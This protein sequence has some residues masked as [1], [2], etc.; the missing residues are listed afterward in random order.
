MATKITRDTIESYLNCKYKGHLKLAG[1]EGTKSDYELLLA[2]SREEVR[3]Q[4][5]AQIL[6]RHPEEVVERDIPLT[7]AALK[8]GAAFVLNA[9]LDDEHVSLA[10]DGLKRVPGPSKLGDFHYV[11]M[12]FYEARQIRKPQRALVDLYGL[13]LSRLQGRAPGYG[14]I[15]HGK[16]CKA[17]RV[18][19]NPDPRKAE[20]LLDELRQAKTAEALPRLILNDHCAVCEFRPRCQQ[21]AVQ[22]DN[23][24]LLRGMKEK[25]VKAYARKGIL[26]VTQ[27]AHTFRPRRK[28]KRAPPRPYRH[29]HALQ[30]LAAR[31]KKVYVF[32]TPQL[33]SSPVRIYLDIE[34]NPE[35]GFDYLVGLIVIEGDNQERHSFWADTRDQ[36]QQ[37][38][39]QFLSVVNRYEDFVVFCYGSYERSFLKRLRK[40]A[41]GKRVVDRVLKSLVNVLSLVYAHFYFPTYSNGL[42]E[43]GA[44]LGCSWSERDASGLQSLVWRTHWEITSNQQWKQKLLNY[45]QE[46]CAALKRVTEFIYSAVNAVGPAQGLPPGDNQPPVTQVQELDR[47][48]NDRKWGPVQFAQSDFEQIN[49]WAYFDYQRERVFVRTCQTLRQR[50]RG[51]KCGRQKVR[52]TVRVTLTSRKCPRCAGTSL[53]TA[54]ERGKAGCSIPRVK[55]AFDL[56]VTPGGI[57]RK[58]IEC[59]TSVHR[60]LACGHDF[61]PEGHARMDKHFHGLKSWALYQHVAHRI[62][63]E[64]VCVMISEF[65]GVRVHYCEGHMFKALMAGYYRRTYR[66]LL[67]KILAGGLLHVDETE[68]KLRTGKGYVW[69]FTNLEE[70]LYLYRPNR[71][72]VFLKKL[73]KDFR[74][75]LVSDFYA[76]Y[77]SLDCPQQKC[78]I[79]LI[80]DMNQELLNNPFDEEL[81]S[82]TGPFGVLLREVVT[83]IDLHGLKRCHLK[84]YDRRV[85][86]FFETLGGQT[87]RSEAAEALRLRLLKYRDK[88]FTF[89]QYDGVPWNNNNAENAIKRFAYYREDRSSSLKE[90][91]LKDYLVLLSLGQTCRYKGVSFLK[92]LLSR[93]RDIDVFV[94]RRR[95]R[96]RP[97]IEMYPKGFFPPHLAWLRD[98]AVQ[99]PA[100][101]KDEAV[102]KGSPSP[103]AG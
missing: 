12:L 44:C 27:L 95:P 29:S 24:S 69:A 42:K 4:A 90:Q 36:E 33:P 17:T 70:A 87:F 20:R 28:G 19:L 102:E 65:F 10:F 80:R 82:V 2:K 85:T 52:P 40:R 76:A 66:G 91:G 79:H 68:V 75:V 22:E 45:N 16:E 1:Q 86:Q 8:R 38:F 39:D 56:R 31:D 58:V 97:L 99:K 74:G 11:P 53:T 21:Q 67:R 101:S 14:I 7:P 30:A 60:C 89:I 64:V 6:A 78:L 98:K 84:K 3:R 34:G 61:I 71:E 96:K 54:I 41:K 48:A 49:K 35:E 25:E 32:G 43:V 77:D 73:L 37:I 63:L 59:R 18:R 23:L 83:T 88:L 46:D 93:E 26:T 81:R 50:R 72:G 62:S 47:L 55:R 94:K 15:W 5:I 57:Q 103:P 92:F 13:L 100:R 9:V 51:K